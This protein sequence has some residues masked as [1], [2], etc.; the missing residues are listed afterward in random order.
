MSEITFHID[1]ETVETA[2]VEKRVTRQYKDR[3][4]RVQSAKVSRVVAHEIDTGEELDLDPEIAAEIDGATSADV[5]TVRTVKLALPQAYKDRLSEMAGAD[6]VVAQYREEFSLG[7]DDRVDPDSVKEWLHDIGAALPQSVTLAITGDD[8]ATSSHDLALSPRTRRSGKVVRGW[9]DRITVP[10]LGKERPDGSRAS[11]ALSYD[12]ALRVR[13][14][15][16]TVIGTGAALH[17]REPIL[18]IS[19]ADSCAD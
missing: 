17:D 13:A 9:E 19:F 1:G 18:A 4:G 3:R 2:T 11:F 6:S 14:S 5:G 12:A 7:K 10:R 16:E 15:Y 8:G